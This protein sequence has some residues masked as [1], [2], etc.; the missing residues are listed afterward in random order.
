MIYLLRGCM[1]GNVRKKWIETEKYRLKKGGLDV[2]QVRSMVYD[3]S[4]WLE[5]ARGNTREVVRG[6]NA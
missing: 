1:Y 4:G 2:R 3:S 5:F 6:M